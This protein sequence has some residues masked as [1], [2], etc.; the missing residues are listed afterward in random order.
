[1]YNHYVVWFLP[2]N[3]GEA[4]E[5]IKRAYEIA[6]EHARK[7]GGRLEPIQPKH[8]YGGEADK[9]GYTLQ[10]GRITVTLPPASTLVIWGFYNADEY[11]D[12]IRFIHDGRVYEWFV[13]PIAYYPERIGVWLEEPLIFR[14]TLY[15]DV[16]TTSTEG[17]DRVYGWPLGYF[18]APLQPPQE[19]KTP[20]KP[21]SGQSKRGKGEQT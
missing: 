8:I 2:L 5:V 16:H 12:F 9:F 1:M 7:A 18:I 19:V 20:R 3:R 11:L 21:K 17:R 10:V 13:E 6:R 15:I 4:V 14:N